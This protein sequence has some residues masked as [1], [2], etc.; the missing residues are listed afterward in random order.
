[1]PPPWTPI[2]DALRARY[3]QAVAWGI[4]T[5]THRD[6]PTGRHPGYTDPAG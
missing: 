1:M 3:D 2:L 6:W 5:N 4:A